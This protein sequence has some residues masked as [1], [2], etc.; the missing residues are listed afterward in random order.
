MIFKLFLL[1]WLLQY[2]RIEVINIYCSENGDRFV[3]SNCTLYNAEEIKYTNSRNICRCKYAGT[4][5]YADNHY[6]C[7]SKPNG[8]TNSSV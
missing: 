5:F 6:E 3:S 7:V 2:I 4:F 8:N 1:M